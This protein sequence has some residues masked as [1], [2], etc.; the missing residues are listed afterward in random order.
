[1]KNSKIIVVLLAIIAF[2]ALSPLIYSAIPEYWYDGEIV[3][4]TKINTAFARFSTS[5]AVTA[6]IASEAANRI[7]SDA[8]IVNSLATETA[9]RISSDTALGILIASETANRISSD[10]TILPYCELYLATSAAIPHANT[11]LIIWDVASDTH[12]AYVSGSFTAPLAGYYLVQQDVIASV[13]AFISNAASIQKNNNQ[14]FSTSYNGASATSRMFTTSSVLWL[15]AGDFLTS[16]FYH[17][18][19]IDKLVNG[20]AGGP[21]AGASWCRIKMLSR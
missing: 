11:K 2:C 3:R 9:N 6:A 15:N 18:D 1:M 12:G 8:I 7:S 16:R 17:E 14:Y 19:G 5:T 4:G 20:A 10:T 21:G 13:G